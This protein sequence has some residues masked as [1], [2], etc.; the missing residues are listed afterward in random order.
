M[1]LTRRLALIV[2]PIV[3]TFA[4]PAFAQSDLNWSITPCRWASDTTVDLTTDFSY[5]GPM[6][7]FSFRF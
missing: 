2:L 7:G 1:S 4:S 5:Q 3:G 6:A